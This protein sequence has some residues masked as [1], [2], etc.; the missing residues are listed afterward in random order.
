MTDPSQ[1][2]FAEVAVPLPLAAPLVYRVPEAFR[3]LAL[4][5][6]RARVPVGKRRLTGFIVRLLGS[7][8]SA[9]P[10]GVKIR[11]LEAVVD[12]TPLLPDDLLRLA[13]FLSEYYLAP[14]GEVLSSMVPSQMAPWGDQ[15]V[16]LTD[17]GALALPRAASEEAV[18]GV[19]R[20][21]GRTTIA[22]LQAAVGLPDL[23]AILERLRSEGRVVVAESR[24]GGSRYRAAVELASGSLEELRERCGRSEPGRQVVDY[25]GAVGRPATVAEVLDAV[26]CRSG[27]IKR[28]RDLGVLRAFTQIERLDLDRHM[29]EP[30]PER[31]FELRQ[32]QVG[33][34]SAV[35]EAV[36]SREYRALHLAGITGAGKTEVYLRAAEATLAQGRGVIILVPEI[37][38]VPALARTLRHRF[39]GN[40]AILHSA[41]SGP[42][43]HQEWSRIRKGTA[44]V[45]LGPR[46]AVF[47]P[48][49]NPGLIV[50]DEE[51]DGSYK[52]DAVPRYNGRD[53]ALYRGREA[54][55]T[56]ILV[57]ATPSLE[58]RLN[59][60]K[61]KMARLELTGRV[62]HGQL[63]E[64]I[65][66]DLRA[67]GVVRHRGEIQFSPR[68]LEELERA[69]AAG[70]QAILLRNRREYSPILLCRACGDETRCEDCGLP[71]TFHKREG[72]LLC[73]Y[74]GSR[75]PVPTQCPVCGESSTLER[76]S[77][78]TSMNPRSFIATP[79]AERLSRSVFPTLPVATSTAS[80]RN[81]RSVSPSLALTTWRSPSVR[82]A[83]TVAPVCTSTPSS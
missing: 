45:V 49:P 25:L 73:H 75:R 15:R 28:L 27:V 17:A 50:V 55:A 74:C 63:P 5:G 41:L 7:S 82:T 14:I 34:V 22:A 76:S 60:E 8:D 9:I 65:L 69:L 24:S 44:P 68:L 1:T 3:E 79:A 70:D 35:E 23:E 66:V 43:R 4:P 19:L 78:L 48:V 57:S 21:L 29:L 38:L 6:A 26:G 58:T 16:W 31:P 39:A 77:S 54:G 36:A 47:A 12:H 53:V 10:D 18:I 72:V 52:Q 81:S 51:Q 37:A 20:E 2:L 40:V 62:G 13:Q 67:A 83:P 80:A 33:A 11:P 46:S 30:E 64:G 56:V 71:R 61:K 42:E 32:D 59:V